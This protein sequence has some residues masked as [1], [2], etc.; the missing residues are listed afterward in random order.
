MDSSLSIPVKDESLSHTLYEASSPYLTTHQQGPTQ[1]DLTDSVVRNNDNRNFISSLSTKSPFHLA[2]SEDRSTQSAPLGSDQRHTDS[3]LFAKP[4]VFYEVTGSDRYVAQP[5]L[6]AKLRKGFFEVNGKW[7]LYH[8]NY[9]SVEC[10]VSFPRDIENGLYIQRGRAE[11]QQ[12]HGFSV[13][14]LASKDGE[15]RE[16]V[17][18]TPKRVRKRE[19]ASEEIIWFPLIANATGREAADRSEEVNI[20]RNVKSSNNNAGESR[21]FSH[22]FERIQFEKATPDNIKRRSQKQHFNLVIELNAQISGGEPDRNLHWLRIARQTSEPFIIRGQ[23]AGPTLKRAIIIRLLLSGSVDANAQDKNGYTVL[24]V[25]PRARYT[26]IL[27][28]LRDAHVEVSWDDWDGR[29]PL[30]R[31]RSQARRRKS[32]FC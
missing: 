29:H 13:K 20:P 2:S 11:L 17:Q 19:A 31:Q 8:R 7:T 26:V 27:H 21:L 4:E 10:A 18:H 1:G 24:A 32:G 14:L 30:P 6:D 16:L 28:L 25:A 12:I 15:I 22:T 5:I 23:P 9:F 3:P